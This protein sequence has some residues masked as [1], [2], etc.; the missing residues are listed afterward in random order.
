MRTSSLSWMLFSCIALPLLAGVGVASLL[1]VPAC[2]GERAQASA[3]SLP[4]A[5]LMDPALRFERLEQL[6]RQILWKSRDVS[7]DR[8][9]SVVRAGVRRQLELLGF[10]RAEVDRLLDDVDAARGPLVSSG[11]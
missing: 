10:Q 3:R 9:R 2:A 4:S 5:V 8:W 11:N 6:R 1:A 7:D